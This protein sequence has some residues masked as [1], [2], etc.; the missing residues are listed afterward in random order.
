MALDYTGVGNLPVVYKGLKVLLEQCSQVDC[1]VVGLP[2]GPHFINLVR[3]QSW[4][5]TN[6][7]FLFIC[8]RS[9]FDFYR[10]NT[11]YTNMIG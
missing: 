9:K 7:S 10:Q 3:Y 2:L 11:N 1:N 8:V 6:G 4:P 5:S